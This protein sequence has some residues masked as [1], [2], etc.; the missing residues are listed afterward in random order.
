MIIHIVMNI[1]KNRW[2]FVNGQINSD[3]ESCLK[4]SKMN[5]TILYRSKKIIDI[6]QIFRSFF[7]I[8]NIKAMDNVM[9]NKI[10]SNIMERKLVFILKEL[11]ICG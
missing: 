6:F 1:R 8:C 2:L 9:N 3:C 7:L 5:L 11:S 10:P 4:Y